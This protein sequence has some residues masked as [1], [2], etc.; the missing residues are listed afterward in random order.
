MSPVTAAESGVPVE[1]GVPVESGLPVVVIR[2][3]FLE[4]IAVPK[5]ST[6]TTIRRID[7]A[8]YPDQPPAIAARFT[9]SDARE[10]IKAARRQ[11]GL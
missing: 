8:V 5:C 3:D 9:V 7:C 10:T 1:P 2:I 4:K 6:P 11:R